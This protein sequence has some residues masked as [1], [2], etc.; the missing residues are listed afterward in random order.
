VAQR[1]TRSRIEPDRSATRASRIAAASKDQYTAQH[2]NGGASGATRARLH[3][4]AGSVSAAERQRQH[5]PQAWHTPR[6]DAG[7]TLRIDVTSSRQAIRSNAIAPGGQHQRKAQRAAQASG[8]ARAAR[9]AT[10]PRSAVITATPRHGPDAR[11]DTPRSARRVAPAA[12]H[13]PVRRT[14]DVRA[15]SDVGAGGS[16]AI[17]R[18]EHQRKFQRAAE[19]PAPFSAAATHLGGR[20]APDDAADQSPS[21]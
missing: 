2:P 19:A 13:D 7:H 14:T 10:S 15:R 4:D 21:R 20:A 16:S 8:V 1:A 5:A 6:F 12:Q 9:T 3:G 17:A 11:R 18:R